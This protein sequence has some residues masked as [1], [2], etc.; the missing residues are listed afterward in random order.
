MAAP[1]TRVIM[2]K[3]GHPQTC[4]SSD[5]DDS[6]CLWCEDVKQLRDIISAL[7]E[8]LGKQAVFVDGGSPTI[9]GDVGLL[10][11]LGGTV[12]IAAKSFGAVLPGPI[13]ETLTIIPDDKPR[14][15]DS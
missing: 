11:V 4:W 2:K 1:E 15:G 6:R 7:R 5:E 9:E 13:I 12:H 3:C 14:K 10:E 8:Q